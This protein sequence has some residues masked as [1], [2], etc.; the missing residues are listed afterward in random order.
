MAEIEISRVRF[1]KI[2]KIWMISTR[3]AHQRWPVVK[4][5]GD[6]TSNG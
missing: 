4:V 6:H 1:G 3:L 5:D 2:G